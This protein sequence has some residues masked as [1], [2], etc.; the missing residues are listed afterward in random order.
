MNIKSVTIMIGKIKILGLLLLAGLMHSCVEDGEMPCPPEPTVDPTTG[1]ALLNLYVERF[2]NPSQDPLND[3]EPNFS[4]RITHLRYYLYGNATQTRVDDYSLVKED[5]ITTV[6]S[7]DQDFYPL[8]FKELPAGDY[9]LLIVGNCVKTILQGDKI[10]ADN[11]HLIFPGCADTEDFFSTAYSFTVKADEV[12]ED[13]VGLLRMHGVVRYAF[14][15]LPED[16]THV[17]VI[18]EDVSNQK[19]LTGDYKESC[20]ANLRY[21]MIPVTRATSEDY[22]MGSFPTLTDGRST[23]H[24]NFYKTE[25]DDIYLTQMV[26]DELTVVRNQLLDVVLDY[27]DNGQISMEVTLNNKWGGSTSG[28]ETE[29]Q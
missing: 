7:N 25:G 3:V 13:K 2:Q 27:N 26:S 18:M 15:N 9:K 1:D 19:W 24:V 20:K 22:V 5:I 12:K 10:S 8:E 23:L 16:V 29:I 28:G 11:L 21:A 4:D 14:N 6:Q 17:E